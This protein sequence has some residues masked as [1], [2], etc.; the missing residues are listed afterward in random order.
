LPQWFTR[1]HP[2]YRTPI[3]SI[4]FMG[5]ISLAASVAVLF[6]SGNQEAFAL[7]QI[8]TWT[9]YGL[10]YLAMFAIPLFAR[11]ERCIRPGVW[12]RIAAASGWLVTLLFVSL[13]VLPVIE[14]QNKW[15]YSLKIITVVTGAN[16][17][18]WTVYRAGQ[19]KNAFT[20]GSK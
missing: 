20:P 7:L 3:N 14:V 18:G 13:S 8:W 1:L 17:L 11:K 10:A 19:R 15:G 6:G 16:V 9:F 2:K 5:A 4:L 12:L